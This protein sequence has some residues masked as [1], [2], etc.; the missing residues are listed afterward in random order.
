MTS[1]WWVYVVECSDGSLYTGVT[2]DITRR[3]KEH[4]SP[5]KGAKYTR[6][7]QPVKLLTSWPV[8]NRSEAQKQEASFKKLSREKKLDF[9]KNFCAVCKYTPCDCQ[10]AYGF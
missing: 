6:S 7:R 8:S 5:T 2:T 3:I 10:W 9:I 1:V 4:N